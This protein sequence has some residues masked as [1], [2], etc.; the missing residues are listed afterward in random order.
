MKT[1]IVML[2][3]S[4][5]AR[6]SAAH[7]AIEPQQ[8]IAFL[9][10][11][12]NMRST[13]EHQYGSSI[14]LWRAGKSYIGHFSN[15]EG[16][17]DTPMGMLENVVYNA[18]TGRISFSAKLTM[19]SHHCKEHSDIPSRDLIE[20]NG[21]LKRESLVGEITFKDMLHDGKVA[22]KQE[23]VLKKAAGGGES[24]FGKAYG[25]WQARTRTILEARGPKW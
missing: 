3:V 12:S 11:Y 13:G 23:A 16:A 4:L 8:G 6:W 2:A 18:K 7:S 21:Q 10:E 20:F 15:S 17:G 5:G 14:M 9:G 25:E 1:W 19:G 22:S 24:F